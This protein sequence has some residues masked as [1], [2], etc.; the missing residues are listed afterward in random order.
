M[1]NYKYFSMFLS[2]LSFY[3]FYIIVDEAIEESQ[4]LL[5]YWYKKVGD[6]S[7]ILILEQL[8]AILRS[9]PKKVVNSF[10]AY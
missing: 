3:F 9:G 2:Q 6:T 7:Y 5:K 1:I 10:L 8:N 4:C